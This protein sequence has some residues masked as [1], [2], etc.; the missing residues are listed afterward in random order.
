ML[1]IPTSIKPSQNTPLSTP[2]DPDD[3]TLVLVSG[4]PNTASPLNGTITTE[5]RSAIQTVTIV[6]TVHDQSTVTVSAVEINPSMATTETSS[7][8]LNSYTVNWHLIL[9]FIISVHFIQ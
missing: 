9:I 2:H 1:T 5:S 4:I 8:R 7:A 3:P 6:S